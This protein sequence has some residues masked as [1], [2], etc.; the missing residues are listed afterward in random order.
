MAPSGTAFQAATPLV[1]E[2]MRTP[3]SRTTTPLLLA[4]RRNTLVEAPAL[5]LRVISM[6]RWRCSTSATEP[7]PERAISS[8]WIT[9]VSAITSTARCGMRLA[10][11]RTESKVWATAGAAK[12]N[13]SDS[14][15]AS[16][17]TGKFMN[18]SI[19]RQP[20]D[21][22][23]GQIDQK[24]TN[25]TLP[26]FGRYPGWQVWPSDLPMRSHSGHGRRFAA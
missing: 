15:A 6:P 8:A 5:P 12:A 11:T 3:S 7:A 16:R 26:P 25:G 19:K 1:D 14:A 9:V 24:R 4:P 23:V 17:V 2:P 21:V 22:P 10:V 20:A 18:S 13:A